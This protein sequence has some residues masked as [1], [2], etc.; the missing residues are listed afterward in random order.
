V[1]LTA[2]IADELLLIAL[3]SPE[4][5]NFYS[6]VGADMKR[7]EVELIITTADQTVEE[8]GVD[9]PETADNVIVVNSP[10]SEGIAL[11]R[12]PLA[13]PSRADYAE[14]ALEATSCGPYTKS[15]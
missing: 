1:R 9:A 2:K 11:L 7:Q 14:R 6:V 3:Y 5:E 12:L 15:G 8:A 4:A 13:G 10:V